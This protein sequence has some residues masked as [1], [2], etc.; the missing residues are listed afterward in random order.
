M[1]GVVGVIQIPHRKT[2]Q[3]VG[4]GNSVSRP[5]DKAG[6]VSTP[7]SLTAYQALLMLQH[8]GQDGAGIVSYDEISGRFYEKKNLGLIAEAIGE[9]DFDRLRGSMALAHNRYATVGSDSIH[10]LQP[11]IS[12]RPFGV[13]MAHNGNVSNYFELRQEIERTWNIKLL[14][15]NDLELILQM[16][17]SKLQQLDQNLFQPLGVQSFSHRLDLCTQ[18]MSTV[19][20]SL[21]GAYSIVGMIAGIGMFGLRDPHGIRPLLLGKKIDSSGTTYMLASES[22]SLQFLGMEIVRDIEPGEMLFITE[23]GHIQSERVD[24]SKSDKSPAPCMFEWVYFAGAESI[25]ENEQVY[26]TRLRM[27][28]ILA[29]VIERQEQFQLNAKIDVVMPVPDTGRT[30]ALALAEKLRL[31]YREGLFKNRY[32]QRSF[33]LSKQQKREMAVHLKLVPIPSEIKGKSILLVD[34]SLVRG[35]TSKKI[36]QHLR[37]MGARHVSLAFTCPPIKFGCTYGIDFPKREDL[38]MARF[39]IEAAKQ[40]LGADALY[41]P[42]IEDLKL[43]LGKS[44]LCTGCL[45]GVYPTQCGG[46][47]VF[48]GERQTARE[49]G[50]E[51]GNNSEFLV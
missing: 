22:S 40:Y 33:I 9:S 46:S 35:T 32:V 17:C 51:M 13:A 6:Q 47:A 2:D 21:D 43:S 44:Q 24:Q 11:M 18:A 4:R 38:L 45:S 23:E 5:S 8:R 1:C 50:L 10:D 15:Q 7:A 48:A 12:G 14:S 39:D 30:A 34:D 42:S 27:G 49:E 19:V 16:F 28:Q 3:E 36:I 29:E 31:P 25:I 26:T 20:Q 41:F 37:N